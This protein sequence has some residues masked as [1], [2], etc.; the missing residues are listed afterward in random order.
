MEPPE[1]LY[2]IFHKNVKSGASKMVFKV[3][4]G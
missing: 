2:R 4:C 3:C 1:K